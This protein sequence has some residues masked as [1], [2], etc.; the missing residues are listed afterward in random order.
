ML[1]EEVVGESVYV[2]GEA[3]V[4]FGGGE[5]GFAASATCIVLGEKKLDIGIVGKMWGRWC[6]YDEDGRM[7]ESGSDSFGCGI[8][9]GF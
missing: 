7:S 4:G 8:N 1:G 9:G 6:T 3:N 5:D 2:E